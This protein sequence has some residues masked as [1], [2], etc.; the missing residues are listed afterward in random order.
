MLTTNCIIHCALAIYFR[1]P[2]LFI[3]LQ[4]IV[5]LV[6]PAS[7]LMMHTINEPNTDTLINNHSNNLDVGDVDDLWVIKQLSRKPCESEF[8]S[9]IT[10]M[11]WNIY[12]LLQVHTS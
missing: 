11:M 9:L 4:L 10:A 7:G 8:K 5:F 6:L 3:C 1:L 12:H 2:G